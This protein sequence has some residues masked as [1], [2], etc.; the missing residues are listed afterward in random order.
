MLFSFKIYSGFLVPVDCVIEYK[1]W[2]ECENQVRRRESR[3]VQEAVGTGNPC[4]SPLPYIEEGV[5]VSHFL[6]NL[7]YRS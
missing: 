2:S 6:S 1:P 5:C 3:I 4:P 7:L